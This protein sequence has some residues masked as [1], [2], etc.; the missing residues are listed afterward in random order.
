MATGASYLI[1]CCSGRRDTNITNHLD[2]HY[3]I[4]AIGRGARFTRANPPGSVGWTIA[5]IQTTPARRE[6]RG[7]SGNCRLEAATQC[8]HGTSWTQ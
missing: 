7:R 5:E 3:A 1:E 8:S 2:A 4:Q 6:W